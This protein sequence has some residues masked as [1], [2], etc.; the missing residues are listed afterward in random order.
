MKNR[1]ACAKLAI[2]AL[3][4]FGW[5]TGGLSAD[6][7]EI[8]PQPDDGN[9][10]SKV[11]PTFGGVHRDSVLFNADPRDT[12]PFESA[13]NCKEDDVD[14]VIV[15]TD[16]ANEVRV[17]DD[18]RPAG[19]QIGEICWTAGYYGGNDEVGQFECVDNPPPDH[20]VVRF[21]EDLG[22]LP[23]VEIGPA[24]GQEVTILASSQHGGGSRLW[25]YAASVFRRRS[26]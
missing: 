16:R 21:Y 11:G 7:G 3:V 24:G 10:V 1:Q 22:G 12:C 19:T 2:T 5:I 23:S 13:T 4:V 6:P 15:M 26:L 8:G 18:F 25:D 20:W 14:G 17:A 9:V